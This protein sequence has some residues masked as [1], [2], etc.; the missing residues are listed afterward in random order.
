MGH[1]VLMVADF[2]AALAFYQ[3]LLGFQISDYMRTPKRHNNDYMTSFYMRTP[4]NFLVEY[5]WGGRQVDVA[6]WQPIEMNTLA[7]FWG[8]EG[9]RQSVLGDVPPPAQ[10]PP[11]GRRAPFQVIEGNYERLSGVCPWWDAMIAKR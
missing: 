2:E 3:D 9:L 11:E 6:T 1:V 4:S 7:S 5:G 8:H 10:L